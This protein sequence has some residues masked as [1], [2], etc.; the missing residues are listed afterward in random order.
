MSRRASAGRAGGRGGGPAP[1]GG[2]SAGRP[3]VL[4]SA[5]LLGEKVR[6][7]G[8]DKRD[9]F[10][11]GALGRFVE[12]VPVCPEVGCGLPV[13]RE[14]MRLA[15]ERGA[16][17][18]VTVATGSDHTRRMARFTAARLRELDGVRLCGYVCKKGS[19]SCGLGAGLFATAFAKRFPFVGAEDEDRLRDPVR[20]EMFVERLFTMHRFHDAVGRGRSRGALVAFHA[21]HEM[22]LLAHGRRVCAEMG[23][24]VA[25][26]SALSAATLF[27]RYRELLARALA[28][29]PTRAKRCD[30]LLRIAGR[31][32]RDLPAAGKRALRE[33]IDRYRRGEAPFAGPLAFIRRG[34]QRCEGADLAR[35]AVL[36][37]HP[38]ELG[39]LDHV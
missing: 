36:D 29:R 28:L 9:A 11:S 38:E 39:L 3:P 23:R 27:T 25:G 17:R 30:M 32:K 26:G 35:Q 16:P 15:G 20:R 8:G 34:A 4:V 22:L 2:L 13:P 10:L 19:P 37:P 24:L 1:P 12:Y 33:R 21:D 6:Y 18:L 5:C 14:P 31:L 7:D